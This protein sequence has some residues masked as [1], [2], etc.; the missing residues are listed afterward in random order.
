MTDVGAVARRLT[1]PL[2]RRAMTVLPAGG[3]L[4]DDVWRRRHQGILVLLWI[5]VPALFVFAL[6]VQSVPH[7]L[8]DA[9]LVAVPAAAAQWSAGRRRR[10]TVFASLGLMTASA[11]LVHLSGGVIEAHFH[12]L[13]MVGVVVLY[14]DWSPFLVAVGFVSIHHA[15][16]GLLSPESLYNHPAALEHPWIWAAIHG[17]SILAMSAVGIANWRLNESLQRTTGEREAKLS[18]AQRLARMGSWERDTATTTP[19]LWSEEMFRIFDL[20]PG[21]APPYDTFLSRVHPDDRHL[22]ERSR[23]EFSGGGGDLAAEFRVVLDDGSLRWIRTRGRVVRAPQGGVGPRLQGTCQDVTEAKGAED[24]RLRSELRY[25]GIVETTHEGVWT[26][27]TGYRTSFVNRR[28]ATMLGFEVDEMLG[29]SLFSVVTDWGRETGVSVLTPPVEGQQAQYEAKLRRKDGTELWA[30]LFLSWSIEPGGEGKLVGLA[31]VNDIT[32]RRLSEE[33]L[34]L[35]L[36]EA[37]ETSQLKSQFLANTSHEIRTPMTV[38]LGMSELL[39]ETDLDPTQRKFA[40][41][42]SRASVTLLAIINDILDFSKIEAGRL[43]LAVADLE[44][45][46]LVDEVGGMLADRARNKGLGLGWGFEPEVPDRVRGDAG[47][48]R[49]ILLNLTS[50]AVKFTD[51]GRVDVRVLRRCAATGSV[52]R[53]EVSDTGIGIDPDDQRRLFQPFSQVDASATRRF[54]GTGLGLAISAMLVE[55]MG[56]HIGVTSKPGTGST[57]WFEIPVEEV[58]A[59]TS[60]AA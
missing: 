48:L 7:A 5:H 28:M 13:V 4:P 57:F 27:D 17:A 49:Q 10:S 45:R 41:G 58:P 53:F 54:G 14:Q 55:A 19:D 39:L 2:V 34:A 33:A 26:F 6:F 18:E 37:L 46:P 35:A 15:V 24:A 3:T 1:D 42:V 44:L 38:V 30:D 9:A 23:T 36:D 12:F 40:E 16:I 60:S 11:V 52:V 22:I 31:M 29:R 20:P 59:F 51:T 43:D 8:L 50:N 32:A 25:R 21:P 47:R 56:G